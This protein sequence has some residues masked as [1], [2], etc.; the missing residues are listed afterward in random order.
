MIAI[1]IEDFKIALSDLSEI[2]RVVSFIF[3]VPLLF[4]LYY[5]KS[6]NFSIFVRALAFILPAVILYLMYVAFRNIKKDQ[7]T[8]TKHVM[9]TVSLAWII[10][11]LVGAL[12]F[13]LSNTL[14]PLD[15]I[16]ESVSGWTTTGMTM[17]KVPEVLFQKSEKDILFYRSFIQWVGGIGIVV[18]ALFVFMRRGTSAMDYYTLEKGDQRIKPSLR[19]TVIE[20]W[21]I[22][23]IYSIV[24]IVLLFISGLSL[25]D[26]INHTFTAIATGGFSTYSDSVGHFNNHPN[27]LIIDTILVVFMLIG[28]ISFLIHF[29]IFEGRYREIFGNIEA[30]YMFIILSLSIILIIVILQVNRNE[31]NILE[32]LRVSVFH[33][34]AASTCTGFSIRDINSWPD[35]VQV[36]LMVLMYIGGFY[37][38]TAGGIKILR[39]AVIINVIQYC[40]KRLSFPRSAV[41]RIK[42][43]GNRIGGEEII[44]V[45]G[46]SIVYIIIAILGSLVLMDIGF[47]GTQ[48]MSLS[49]SAMGNVG[50]TPVPSDLW[51][52]INPVGK[53][54]L[55]ILMLLG[56]LEIFPML[57]FLT[58]IF[59]SYR[60]VKR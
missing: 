17:I 47:N 6:Y 39:F 20:I 9:I 2:C 50:L 12:P 18:L 19:S 25:F 28:S 48:S 35:S 3:L 21:K 27:G 33:V 26:S 57:V 15:S 24:C 4:T 46:L 30:K 31:T 5:A 14:S 55:I 34:V 53:I 29:R 60:G 59:H 45:F 1:N 54:T 58:S 13:I 7:R 16:F 51:F 8:R 37:G 11:T 22:Y 52:N 38:S 49:L 44:Y 36:I 10:I 41:L 32:N 43:K 23:S 42:I 40:I 56:R